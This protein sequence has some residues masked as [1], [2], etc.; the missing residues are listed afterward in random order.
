M[1]RLLKTCSKLLG[2]LNKQKVRLWPKISK[3]FQYICL[4]LSPDR[5]RQNVNDL[6]VDYCRGWGNRRS[7]SSRDSNPVGLYWSSTHLVLC[8]PD[9]PCWTWA[10]I[11]V[12]ALMSDY[13]LN[14]TK[15]SS[16][17][18]CCQWHHRPP[19]Q[20]RWPSRSWEAFDLKYILD[21]WWRYRAE[22]RP[23]NWPFSVNKRIFTKKRAFKNNY[24]LNGLFYKNVEF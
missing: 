23:P 19:P 12:Q 9:E 3:S 4:C 7:G 6:N 17:I 14:W 20:R 15:G 24:I 1:W 11:W 18:Q 22:T 10:Q 2:Y 8:E 21:L 13:S 5:T 16:A